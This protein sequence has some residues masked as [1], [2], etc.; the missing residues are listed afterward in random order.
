MN[1]SFEITKNNKQATA[2][3]VDLQTLVIQQGA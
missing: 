2:P 1:K 3:A